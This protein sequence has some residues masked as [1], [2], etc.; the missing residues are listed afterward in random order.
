MRT[1]AFFAVMLS[2]A[3][4]AGAQPRY[5]DEPRPRRAAENVEY[6]YA[7]VLRSDP[8]YEYYTVSEPREE[9]YDERVVTREPRGG[10]PTGGTVLG[11]IIGGV[12]GSNIGSG[13]GRRAATVAGAVIGGSVGRNVDR[14][15]GPGRSYETRE[16]RCR[17]VEEPREEQRIAGY[18]VEYRYRG[19]V[20]VS[21][22]D[23]DPGERLRVRVSVS[24]AE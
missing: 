12:V 13:D 6:A 24:P 19:E 23:H 21:R 20:Y 5:D 8:V 22:L 14:N 4:V 11:A 18:D 17:I 10:D 9:C 7:D 16:E 3:P 2:L 1:V 15:N